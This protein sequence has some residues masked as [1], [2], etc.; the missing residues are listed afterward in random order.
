[1]R[2]PSAN[3]PPTK[4]QADWT[5]K[6]LTMQLL[7][8]VKSQFNGECADQRARRECKD[9]GE[10]NPREPRVETQRGTEQRRRGRR[11]PKQPGGDQTQGTGY[12][13]ARSASDYAA[14]TA[15]TISTR[16]AQIAIPDSM[17]LP[18]SIRKPSRSSTSFSRCWAPCS[19]GPTQM[20]T[21]PVAFRR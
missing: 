8:S 9:R 6:R 7:C 12:L 18:D 3:S 17:R 11:E 4:A 16:R 20:A 19:G 1:M 5:P 14:L 21:T 13:R 2:A 10:D 15:R